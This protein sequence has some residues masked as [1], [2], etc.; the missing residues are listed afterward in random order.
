[1]L[2]FNNIWRFLQLLVTNRTH[3]KISYLTSRTFLCNGML[4]PSLDCTSIHTSDYMPFLNL[5]NLHFLQPKYQGVDRCGHVTTES[6]VSQMAQKT[7]SLPC[8]NRAHWSRSQPTLR[9]EPLVTKRT[10]HCENSYTEHIHMMM[11]ACGIADREQGMCSPT[12]VASE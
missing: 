5:I 10:G 3:L 6:Q 2:S 8:D 1:M 4:M 9:M 7:A 12:Q 11:T